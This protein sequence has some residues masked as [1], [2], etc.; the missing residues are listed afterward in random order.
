[1]LQVVARNNLNLNNNDH[2]A[3]NYKIL[4]MVLLLTGREQHTFLIKNCE[5]LLGNKI[6]LQNSKF[7][8]KKEAGTTNNCQLT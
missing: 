7:D 2:K 3:D 8:F 5:F 1:M 4:F 6:K